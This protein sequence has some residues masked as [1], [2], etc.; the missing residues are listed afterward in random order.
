MNAYKTDDQYRAEHIREMGEPLGTVFNALYSEL[1]WLNVKWVEYVELFGVNP[2]RIELLN[3]TAPAFF[4]IVQDVLLKDIMLQVARLTDPVKSPGK[5][6]KEN[7]TVQELPNLV[8]PEIKGSIQRLV[9]EAKARTEFCRQWRNRHI[10]HSD[11]ALALKHKH[12]TP[13]PAASREKLREALHAIANILNAVSGP[14]GFAPSLFEHTIPALGGAGSLL[15][16]LNSRPNRRS[17]T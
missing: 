12:A 1:L 16:V 6:E 17:R 9:E 2:E 4:G 14:Y 7:L 5:E 15:E 8:R 13:L 10:A 3:G 11:R